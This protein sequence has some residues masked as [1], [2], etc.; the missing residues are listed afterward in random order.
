MNCVWLAALHV[1]LFNMSKDSWRSALL[2]FS[3]NMLRFLKRERGP[4][5]IGKLFTGH[6]CVTHPSQEGGTSGCLKEGVKGLW[7][8]R[9]EG[10][11]DGII[12]SGVTELL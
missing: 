3:Q 4:G 8:F 1:L 5:S 7:V 6:G 10:G 12:S 2:Q 11:E 9:E